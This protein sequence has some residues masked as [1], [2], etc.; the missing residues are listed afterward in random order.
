[1]GEWEFGRL[2]YLGLLLVAVGGWL[3][4]EHRGRI[5]AA[6]RQ[7]LA[8]GLLFLGVVAA[9]GLWSDIRT[10]V[11]PRQSVME[12]GTQIELPRAPDGHY[13]LTL[14][15]AGTPVRFMVDTG[16]TEV[17]LSDRDARRLGIDPE[18]L[19]FTGRAQTANGVI[20]TARVRLDEVTLD[21]FPEGRIAASVGDGPLG[22]SLLG[23]D[24]LNRFSRIE[25]AAGR[26]VLTR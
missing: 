9:Y 23:M 26:L 5:G 16:A 10:Q 11:A 12:A 4:V 13:Y 7:L 6:L 8:W 18:T 24:Y 20:R 3:V 17:V 21:G 1:M 2:V 25:I 22:M 19:V 14:H 15:I